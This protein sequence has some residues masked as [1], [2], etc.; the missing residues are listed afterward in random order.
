MNKIKLLA[1]ALVFG[2]ASA[3]YAAYPTHTVLLD[4]KA[5]CCHTGAACCESGACCA[6]ASGE[7]DSC[8]TQAGN[9]QANTKSAKPAKPAKSAKQ[10]KSAADCCSGGS[11]C[12]GGA[13]CTKHSTHS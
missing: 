11:C 8:G 6:T 3:T 7:H 12:T 9:K 5:K 2:L 13:C 4:D 10:A 1:L